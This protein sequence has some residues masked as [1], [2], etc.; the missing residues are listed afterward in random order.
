M[1]YVSNIVNPYEINRKAKNNIT[2]TLQQQRL[3]NTS[4][5]EFTSSTYIS[6]TLQF[7]RVGYNQK[8]NA[9]RLS[10]DIPVQARQTTIDKPIKRNFD[11][12]GI[13]IEKKRTRHIMGN[14]QRLRIG[15]PI[16]AG[17]FAENLSL[18]SLKQPAHILTQNA[19]V[20]PRVS[21]GVYICIT[22]LCS[23]SSE[24]DSLSPV[25]HST[26]QMAAV[27]ALCVRSYRYKSAATDCLAVRTHVCVCV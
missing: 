27:R 18:G 8:S 5:T 12:R 2:H 22:L 15:D 1:S 24:L 4:R 16:T 23:S 7:A 21:I 6:I 20:Y 13:Y 3:D 14:S 9:S 26:W 25:L 10:N 11:S 17:T 19:R